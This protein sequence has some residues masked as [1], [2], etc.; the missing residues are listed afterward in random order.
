[1]LLEVVLTGAVAGGTS[2][3]FATLGEVV[4]ERAGVVNLGTEG[5]MLAGAL[6][7]YI[8]GIETGQPWLG[9]LAGAAAGAVLAAVLAFVVLVR[10]ANQ[11][12]AG[13]VVTFLGIGLTSLFGQDYV[14]QGVQPLEN[15]P[16]PGLADL[17]FVG[18]ILF[19]H[20]PLTYL[21]LLAAVA[22]W[23]AMFRT[24]TGLWVRAA[25]ERPEVLR[26]FGTSPQLVRAGAL[27]AGGAL[28]GTGG[29]QLATAYT[30]T[31]SENM[32]VGRG[33]VAVG[34]VI[35]AAW[36]PLKA[37]LG[38]YLFS[39][40]IALQLELQA[41]GSD[42]SPYLLQALPYLVVV[43]VLAALSRRRLHAV[44]ESLTR[45]FEGAA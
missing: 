39:G 11:V 32:T 6:T 42:L 33:F 23:F 8:V 34:L 1:M 41:R 19:D 16:I 37:I 26:T 3:L 4:S 28:A 17:P 2:L 31:W 20:D 7:A 45:V 30:R 25:G 14:G 36:N 24:R 10:G 21:S 35:F 38:A 40:A 22:I 13:L 12:A 5:C 27:L 43:I 18:P 9:V 44:P 15:L 29:A